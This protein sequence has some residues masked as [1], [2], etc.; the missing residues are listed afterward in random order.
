ME[1]QPRDRSRLASVIGEQHRVVEADAK[2]AAAREIDVL[3]FRGATHAAGADEDAGDSALHAADDAADDRADARARADLGDLAF[4]AFAFDRIDHSR[5]D[6][7]RSAV[8][9][10]PCVV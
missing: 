7:A 3:A 2:H 6:V 8:N 4:E 9:V 10:Q 1:Y 5:T